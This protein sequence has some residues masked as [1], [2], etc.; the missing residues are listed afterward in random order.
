[1]QIAKREKISEVSGC[2]C[3]DR[4]EKLVQYIEL[5]VGMVV[6]NVISVVIEEA[7]QGS[8]KNEGVA[9]SRGFI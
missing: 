3:V 8:E 2:D 1:M 7:E 9:R 6:I 4:D 5:S